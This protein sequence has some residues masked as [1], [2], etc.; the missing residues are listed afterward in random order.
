MRSHSD[1]AM[2][3][4]CHRSLYDRLSWW[5]A[6]FSQV[7]M[8]RRCATLFDCLQNYFLNVD[9]K[10]SETKRTL[11]ERNRAFRSKLFSAM[12]TIKRTGMIYLNSNVSSCQGDVC[13]CFRIA[14]PETL[15][16][17]SFHEHEFESLKY[18]HND[19][20]QTRL[21]WVVGEDVL[22]GLFLFLVFICRAF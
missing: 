6:W 12:K 21:K 3:S 20:C 11:V 15:S 18:K 4:E 16:L 14:L 17:S 5:S 1:F 10:A 13:F 22:W 7:N 19:H 8:A 2:I 9:L